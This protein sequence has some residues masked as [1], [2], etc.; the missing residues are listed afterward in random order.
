[1]CVTKLCRERR[2]REREERE[3]ADGMQNQKQE[4]HIKM[5]GKEDRTH[6]RIRERN[7]MIPIVYPSVDKSTVDFTA[8]SSLER[9]L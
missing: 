6:K 3:E 8:K 5:W 7:P 2:R 1:M 4:P 9:P